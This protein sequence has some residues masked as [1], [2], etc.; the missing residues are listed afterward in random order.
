MQLDGVK[1][2]ANAKRRRAAL[3]ANIKPAKIVKCFASRLAARAGNR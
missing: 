2:D 1:A 3:I